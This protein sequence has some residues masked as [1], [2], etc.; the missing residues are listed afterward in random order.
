[1]DLVLRL[2]GKDAD[3]NIDG[4]VIVRDMGTPILVKVLRG[5]VSA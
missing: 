1:M 3:S 4:S 5:G 2:E